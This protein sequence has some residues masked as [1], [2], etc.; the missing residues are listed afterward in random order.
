MEEGIKKFSLLFCPFFY[1]LEVG[2]ALG[3]GCKGV[4]GS[5]Y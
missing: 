3:A 5:K 2:L 4:V 1:F